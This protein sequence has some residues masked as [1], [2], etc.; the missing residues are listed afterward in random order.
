MS[1]EETASMQATSAG[2]GTAGF[3]LDGKVVWIT[4]ASRGLGRAIAIGMARAGADVAV[5]A[6][7]KDRL[8]QLADEIGGKVLVTPGA[9]NEPGEMRAVADSIFSW[10]GRLDVLVNMAG[11]NPT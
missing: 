6:R 3:A 11:I 2:V 1:L 7:D 10:Q 8:Q 9:V 4:G 5:T